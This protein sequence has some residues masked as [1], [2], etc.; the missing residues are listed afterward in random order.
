MRIDDYDFGRICIDGTEYRADVIAY[1]NRVQ[2]SWWR[3]EGHRLLPEDLASVLRDPPDVLVV[4]T[5][6]YG[7]MEVPQAT[8]E[9]LHCRGVATHVAPTREAVREFNRLQQEGAG[10]VAALHLTC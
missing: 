7:N 3:K 6:Y 9:A 2:P 8:V 5:G 4:G 1:S 10:V